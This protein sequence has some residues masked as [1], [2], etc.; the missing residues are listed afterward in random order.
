MIEHT[1]RPAIKK[2]LS[3]GPVPKQVTKNELETGI[4]LADLE[5]DINDQPGPFTATTSKISSE[6]AQAVALSHATRKFGLNKEGFVVKSCDMTCELKSTFLVHLGH[7]ISGLEAINDDLLIELDESGKILS[8]SSNFYR[9]LKLDLSTT[10]SIF[11]EQYFCSIDGWISAST[12]S[13]ASTAP[14][15]S[16]SSFIA[17]PEALS[18]LSSY[19][20]YILTPAELDA[21]AFAP[22]LNKNDVKCFA[23][24]NL[25]RFFAVNN[26]NVTITPA[27]LRSDTGVLIPVY[28]FEALQDDQLAHAYVS[29]T[30]GSILSLINWEN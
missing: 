19:F 3:F 20:G 7:Y 15:T 9:S 5:M 28:E 8:I 27:F 11:N 2:R 23:I 10:Q 16:S 1:S 18:K 25:P 17:A 13:T 14:T 26:T 6:R 29:S 12:G 4:T 30:D 24:S 21:I 22:T